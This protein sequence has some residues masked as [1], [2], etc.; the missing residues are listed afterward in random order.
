MYTDDDLK[1]AL[2]AGAIDRINYLSLA[3]F[4]AARL[5]LRGTTA[6]AAAAAAVPVRR[7]DLTHLLWYAGALIV[8]A[9]M[10]IFTTTAFNALG[11]GALIITGLFYAFAF[12]AFGNA[13]WRSPETRTPGG[14]ALTVAVAMVPMIIYGIQDA[15]DLWRFA[16]GKPGEYKAFF[17]YIHGSW[18]YMELAT[19]AAAA[20][21]MRFRPFPFL[22]MPAGIALWFFSMD[23]VVWL[24]H[25]DTVATRANV[26]VL[27]GLATIA[28]AWAVDLK[29]RDKGD[30]AF[31]L[32]IFGIM[33]FWGGLTAQDS[34]GEIGPLLYC[35]INV[36][37]LLFAVYMNRRVYAV[38]GTIGVATYLGHL[39]AQVF[40]DFLAFSFVLTLI[41]VGVIALGI[42]YN[43]NRDRFARWLDASLPAGLRRLRPH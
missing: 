9:A 35:L 42:W 8:M 13:L 3:E 18:I 27:F 4:L 40:R 25:F 37:L 34:K 38:F 2:D 22:L 33:T 10:T 5:A 23:I 26:S 15:L 7:F 14:L 41:G 17:P 21:V 6:P 31:W 28:A 16:Q 39:A 36:G 12:G 20:L 32:H 1:A 29:A 30:Y 24:A 19:V 43:K 11:G